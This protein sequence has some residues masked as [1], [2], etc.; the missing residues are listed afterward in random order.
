M[1]HLFT[2]LNKKK[3]GGEGISRRINLLT[4]F[5]FNEKLH[6]GVA[7]PASICGLA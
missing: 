4:I 1:E 2:R 5:P 6:F 3:E 7:L